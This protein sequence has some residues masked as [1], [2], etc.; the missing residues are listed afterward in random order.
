MKKGQ[1]INS[2]A[3]LIAYHRYVTNIIIIVL[4]IIISGVNALIIIYVPRESSLNNNYIKA[5]TTIISGNNKIVDDLGDLIQ[6]K[7][8]SKKAKE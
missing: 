6:I 3:Q 1:K 7:K 4:V 5:E 2:K 8:L